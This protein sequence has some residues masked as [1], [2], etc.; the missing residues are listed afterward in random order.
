MLRSRSSSRP[1]WLSGF[2]LACGHRRGQ[3]QPARGKHPRTVPVVN[4]DLDDQT[5][6]DTVRLDD[7]DVELSPGVFGPCTYPC[8]D[9][10][11]VALG[12]HRRLIQQLDK[13]PR[14]RHGPR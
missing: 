14:R 5:S 3:R 10:D 11:A 6:H 13:L 12:E 7:P 4:D 2:P 1:C 8:H 9:G